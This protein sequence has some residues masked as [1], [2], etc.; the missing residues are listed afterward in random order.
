MDVTRFK[1]TKTGKFVP[2]RTATGGDF[3]FIPDPL[4]PQWDFPTHLWP[5]LAEA[6]ERLGHLDGIGKTLP[7]PELLLSPL[8][9]R[10]ALAS[11]RIEGTYATAQELMLF[12]MSPHEPKSAHDQANAWLEVYNYSRALARGT[13]R[14]IELPFCG[15]L[16]K[17]LHGILMDGVRGQHSKPGEWRD[18]QVAIGSDRRYIPPPKIE[19]LKCLEELERYINSIDNRYDPLVRS[20]IVHYQIEAIHPFADGNGRVGR[21]VLS[22]MIA[23]W[24]RL[25]RP[26]LYMSAF[27]EKH[28]NEYVDNLFGVSTEGAWE[29]WV[30]FCIE[31]TI[32]QANDAIRRCEKL[33]K[34]REEMSDKL[35]THGSARTAQIIELLFSNPIVRVSHLRKLFDISYPT[36]QS[37]IDKLI[38]Y[39]ILRPLPDVRPKAFYSP[40]VMAAAYEDIDPLNELNPPDSIAQPFSQNDRKGVIPEY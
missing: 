7:D 16:I 10:E 30:N 15:K 39:E 35:G 17:E 36:A 21:V 19:M 12:E 26:W 4:P 23:H 37:D 3:A 5:R 20:Y 31:G 27:F 40:A 9:N 24:C 1:D 2:I 38:K 8:K 14:L 25:S 28:K 13:K 18:L 6:K 32:Q 22:L 29:K 11:S 33:R 34:L